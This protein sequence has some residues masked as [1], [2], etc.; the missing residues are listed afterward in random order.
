MTTQETLAQK[1]RRVDNRLTY[2]IGYRNLYNI[3]VLFCCAWFYMVVESGGFPPTVVP[4]VVMGTFVVTV[5]GLKWF[6][7]QIRENIDASE[8]RDAIAT[9]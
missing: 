9:G 1:I 5:L 8:V 6:L 2:V 7:M 4:S 3:S